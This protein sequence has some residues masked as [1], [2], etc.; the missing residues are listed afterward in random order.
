MVRRFHWQKC[1]NFFLIFVIV[2][3]VIR[4]RSESRESVESIAR[5][6]E[7]RKLQLKEEMKQKKLQDYQKVMFNPEHHKRPYGDNV[8]NINVSLAEKQPLLRNI[9]DTRPSSCLKRN[10]DFAELPTLSVIIPFYNE[11][12]SMLL[13]TVHSILERTPP[14][15]LVDLILMNDHSSNEDLTN[16]LPEYVKLLPDKVSIVHRVSCFWCN[17]L[18]SLQYPSHKC[19]SM[20]D[21][22]KRLV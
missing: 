16:E 4:M 20:F 21:S 7:L 15:L 11:A 18:C 13:R 9:P 22:S 1:I 5:E 3:M 19:N 2:T 14:E 17:L 8:Y 6:R 10:F 12:L